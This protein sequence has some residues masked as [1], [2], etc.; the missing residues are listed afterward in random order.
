MDWCL[1]SYRYNF[2]VKKISCRYLKS[3]LSGLDSMFLCMYFMFH[4][5]R[6]S[7]G[8]WV[9][10]WRVWVVVIVYAVPQTFKPN[11]PV[12]IRFVSFCC[13]P[14]NIVLSFKLWIKAVNE[15][16]LPKNSIPPNTPLCHTLG[17]AELTTAVV[18]GKVQ[19]TWM[20]CMV[21]ILYWLLNRIDM[22]ILLI[23]VHLKVH[24]ID[25]FSCWN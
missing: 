24:Y 25:A 10:L 17:L 16:Q 20:S 3:A 6:R 18:G 9:N 5:M 12:I 8:K 2:M 14:N 11:I 19:V 1:Q 13:S 22:L 7:I 21:F 23:H 4:C 15:L